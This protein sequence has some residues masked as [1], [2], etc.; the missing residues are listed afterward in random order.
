MNAKIFSLMMLLAGAPAFAQAAPSSGAA[1]ES[2]SSDA[3]LEARM[4]K[5]SQR[6]GLDPA[7]SAAVR[8]T[9]TKYH[10]QLAPLRQNAIQTRQALRAE[11]GKATP[12]EA[13]ISQLTDQLASQKQQMQAV[14]KQKMQELRGELSP[15]QFARLMT[16]RHQ[17]G[18]RSHHR[19]DKS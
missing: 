16:G 5:L 12:D 8:A 6:L 18:R 2:S 3:R 15:S 1:V 11:L 14:H 10:A 7:E 9:F 13:R 4:D 19:Y 17:F